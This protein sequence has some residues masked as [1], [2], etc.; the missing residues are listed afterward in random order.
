MLRGFYTAASGMYAQQRKTDLLT[1]N[2][3]NVNTAGFKEDQAAIRAFPEMLLSRFET[4]TNGN[5][6]AKQV[7]SINTGVYM[8]ETIPRFVQGDQRQTD[9]LTD[10]A[11]TDTAGDPV[12][13]TV[14]NGDETKYT[15]NGRFTIDAEGLLTT[16]G[17]WPVL[18]ENGNRIT[19]N[20]DQFTVDR[21]GNIE[22]NGEQVARLGIVTTENPE[23]LIKEGN[24]LFRTEDGIPL[25][26]ANAYSVSQG[27]IE[28]STVDPS[29]TMTEMLTAYRAF[30][31]NQKILQAYDRSMEK[32]VNEVGRVNG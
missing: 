30:E 21:N 7:G 14:E 13:F 20:S 12:F 27:F 25:D 9:L 18:D 29:R 3:A 8:Q 26:I 28:G 4:S 1:N 19:L 11:L 23:A 5:K 2:M 16:D 24:G 31:A 6:N 10:L 17:G 32:T 15:R 22:E